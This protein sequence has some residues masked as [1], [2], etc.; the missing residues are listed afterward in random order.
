MSHKKSQKELKNRY[1]NLAGAPWSPEKPDRVLSM[2]GV[3]C[4]GRNGR[5]YPFGSYF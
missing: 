2:G 4:R 1:L 5:I 3:F